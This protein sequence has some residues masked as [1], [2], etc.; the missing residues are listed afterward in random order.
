MPIVTEYICYFEQQNFLEK[1]NFASK[2]IKT[3]ELVRICTIKVEKK[4]EKMLI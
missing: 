2:S 3:K 1:D 4:S